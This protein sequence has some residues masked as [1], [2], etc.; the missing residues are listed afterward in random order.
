MSSL[1]KNDERK[2]PDDGEDS[3]RDYAAGVTKEL[4]SKL[5]ETPGSWG[6]C[7]LIDTANHECR[8][9]WEDNPDRVGKFVQLWDSGLV[10]LGMIALSRS[11]DDRG[12]HARTFLLNQHVGTKNEANARAL[13]EDAA[14]A[15]AEGELR[16]NQPPLRVVIVP[17]VKN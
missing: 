11:R 17:W 5:G 16:D 6:A 1:N 7:V 15:M 10:P 14:Q 3:R 9:V 4:D 8:F 13:L 12:V 2:E